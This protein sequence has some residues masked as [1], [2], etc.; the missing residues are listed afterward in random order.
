M[1]QQL[2][3]GFVEEIDK[4]LADKAEAERLRSKQANQDAHL[5]W[6]A[7]DMPPET[8]EWDIILMGIR[9]DR[10]VHG[11]ECEKC[12][13]GSYNHCPPHLPMHWSDRHKQFCLT[14]VCLKDFLAKCKEWGIKPK[15]LGG[16]LGE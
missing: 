13:L 8:E 10:H 1:R 2:V 15:Y 5:R 9:L 16:P 14:K 4:E 3:F 12:N 7:N 6:T 11:S